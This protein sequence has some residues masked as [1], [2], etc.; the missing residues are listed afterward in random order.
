MIVVVLNTKGGTGKT[1]TS[2]HLAAALHQSRTVEVWD[3][4]YKQASSLDWALTSAERDDPLPF[5]VREVD[6]E[7][8]RTA[9]D[10]GGK[11]VIIIDAPPNEGATLKAALTKAD[12]VIVTTKTTE[13]DFGRTWP[14]IENLPS[15]I[16]Y[17]VLL[18]MVNVQTRSYRFAREHLESEGIPVFSTAIKQL[19]G[20]HIN[21]NSYPKKLYGYENVAA[22]LIEAMED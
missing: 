19:E 16:P 2:I 7:Q 3:A 6:E 22:E 5:P 17:L 10:D 13:A 9:S 14:T 1:T 4:E 18:T 12:V 20:V 15:R 11:K 8:L 21:T